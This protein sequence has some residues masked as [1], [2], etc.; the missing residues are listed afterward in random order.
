MCV[1]VVTYQTC[2]SKTFGVPPPTNAATNGLPL[3]VVAAGERVAPTSLSRWA[4]A[5]SYWVRRALSVNVRR[6]AW[7]VL[8]LPLLT[9]DCTV[10]TSLV[11]HFHR[12]RIDCLWKPFTLSQ[13]LSA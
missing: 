11:C 9:V 7:L 5:R 8:L 6:L 10:V 4:R 3:A 13:W 2:L 12:F 1:R